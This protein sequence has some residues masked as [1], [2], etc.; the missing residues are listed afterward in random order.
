MISQNIQQT[1]AGSSG[2][3]SLRGPLIIPVD[4]LSQYVQSGTPLQIDVLFDARG[5]FISYIIPGTSMQGDIHLTPNMIQKEL[6]YKGQRYW[7]QWC[8]PNFGADNLDSPSKKYTPWIIGSIILVVLLIGLIYYIFVIRK[9]RVTAPRIQ[10]VQQPQTTRVP[11]TL[12][13]LEDI[14][15][16]I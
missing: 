1:G 2:P 12:H 11:K 15:N 14:D 3:E 5:P 13:S 4:V 7:K 16:L 6:Y 10:S 9:K 8:S